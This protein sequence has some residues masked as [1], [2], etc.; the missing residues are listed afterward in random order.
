MCFGIWGTLGITR[1]W[2]EAIN[3]WAGQAHTLAE[4]RPAGELVRRW[5]A[6]ARAA[7]EQARFALT[8]PGELRCR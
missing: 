1:R 2:P 6:E 5:S 8:A 3:L 7:I 4:D